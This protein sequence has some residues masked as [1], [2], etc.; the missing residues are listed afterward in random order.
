MAHVACISRAIIIGMDL[1]RCDASSCRARA[2]ARGTVAPSRPRR[3]QGPHRARGNGRVGGGVGCRDGRGRVE[4]AELLGVGA[5][6]ARLIRFRHGGASSRAVSDLAFD[7]ESYADKFQHIAGVVAGNS[8]KTPALPPERQ[9]ADQGLL[10]DL[11]GREARGG[12]SSADLRGFLP[13]LALEF[14][15][16]ESAGAARQLDRGGGGVYMWWATGH[17]VDGSTS[18]RT[19]Q[20]E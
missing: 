3:T 17:G 7:L 1:A 5:R 16:R 4:A 12:P 15:I 19:A 14:R 18:R 20:G 8:Q 2:T 9:Q 11:R 6:S 10:S 13:G